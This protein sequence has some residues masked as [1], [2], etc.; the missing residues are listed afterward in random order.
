MS[1][2]AVA[3]RRSGGVRPHAPPTVSGYDEFFRA[4]YPSVL[5]LCHGLLGDRARAE[6][7]AQEAFLRL[8]FN[9]NRVARYERPDAW[10]RRVAVRLALRVQHRDRRRV[11]LERTWSRERPATAAASDTDVLELLRQ[12]PRNQR[13][14]VTL[15]YVDDLATA[16]IAV[17]MG[18]AEATAR[19]HLHRG[20]QRLAELLT[21]KEAR[22]RD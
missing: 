22:P 15:R 13:I 18:C 20:R 1:M 19:V 5:R 8:H 17:I 2:G 16:D 12:L 9:W 3:V 10:I 11:T 14:A 7:V 4:E 6:E 21:W